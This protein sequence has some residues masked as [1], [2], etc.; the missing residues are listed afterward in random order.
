MV[1]SDFGKL[2]VSRHLS[3][4]IAWAIAGFATAVAAAAR[5]AACRNCRRFMGSSL[6]SRPAADHKAVVGVFRD[7]PPQIL[8]IAE[9]LDRVPDR[10]VIGVGCR[11]L[12]I[13]L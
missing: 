12:R 7:L 3:S 1:S 8:V 9:S 6:R 11:G 5:P 10:L 13:D 2:E 4:G